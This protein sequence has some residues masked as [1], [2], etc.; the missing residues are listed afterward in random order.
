MVWSDAEVRELL[1]QFVP[2]ADEVNVILW[3]RGPKEREF[4]QK[5]GAQ[6]HYGKA[7]QGI[8]A[9]TPSGLFLGS[10]N[11][12]DAKVVAE[13]LRKALEKYRA[14]EK[15]ERVMARKPSREPEGRSLYP[16][17]GLVLQS[18]SRDLP[19]PDGSESKGFWAG[20]WNS[21]Y[22]WFTKAEAKSMVPSSREPGARQAA[23]EKLVRRLATCHLID[24]VRG[25]VTMFKPEHVKKAELTLVV[26]GVEGDRVKLRIEGATKVEEAGVR[27]VETAIAG[28]ATWDAKVERFVR[29]DF[30]AS[31]PRFGNVGA[32]QADPG[33]APLGVAFRLAPTQEPVDRVPPAFVLSPLGAKYFE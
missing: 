1:K 20:A 27:G 24:N 26:T 19:R 10:T 4:F 12:R 8:Y 32:R 29:F 13:L 16:E 23:P 14:M 5:L 25:E 17:G 28:A 21:D 15:S 18:F 11:Q 6:G 31:G 2:A 9:A 7:E 33:P 30:V 22:A 3:Q